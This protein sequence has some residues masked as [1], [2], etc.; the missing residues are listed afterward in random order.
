M[1]VFILVLIQLFAVPSQAAATES[2]KIS[3][4][5][6]EFVAS[7]LGNKAKDYFVIAKKAPAPNGLTVVLAAKLTSPLKSAKQM[8]GR[9]F[10]IREE[11]NRALRL[12]AEGQVEPKVEWESTWSESTGRLDLDLTHSPFFGVRFSQTIE[13]PSGSNTTDQ[14]L[15]FVSEAKKLKLIGRLV[16]GEEDTQRGPNQTVKLKTELRVDE[17]SKDKPN[18][19]IILT[20]SWEIA[21][22]FEEDEDPLVRTCK[23]ERRYSF[24]NGL[25]RTASRSCGQKLR[26]DFA[27]ELRKRASS[28]F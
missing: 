24:A 16:T 25:Y 12:E 19:D 13:F 26:I 17:S 21:P 7:Q 27:E 28:T 14:L 5:V 8:K 10:L 15:L 11:A 20:E 1:M 23:S 4:Q 18:K 2:E 6:S 3:P 9:I 22:L